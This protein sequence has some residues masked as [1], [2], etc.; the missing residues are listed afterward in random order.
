MCFS[1]FVLLFGFVH[2]EFSKHYGLNETLESWHQLFKSVCPSGEPSLET[3]SQL[4]RQLNPHGDASRFCEHLFRAFDV[5]CNG[6]ADFKEFLLA[7]HITS[8]C[9][10]EDIIHY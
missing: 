8:A 9:N 10:A 2:Y 3:F 4:Y 1:N 7:I 6:V 5:D